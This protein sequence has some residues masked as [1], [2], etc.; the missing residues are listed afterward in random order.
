MEQLFPNETITTVSYGT[1]DL[2]YPI[3]LVATASGKI[4]ILQGDGYCVEPTFK[5]SYRSN[6]C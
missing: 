1:N 3:V 2:G 6:P 5:V 4:A